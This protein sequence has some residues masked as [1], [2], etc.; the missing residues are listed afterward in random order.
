MY[1]AETSSAYVLSVYLLATLR[2]DLPYF[3]LPVGRDLVRHPLHRHRR[4]TRFRNFLQ[5]LP[6]MMSRM[7][8]CFLTSSLKLCVTVSCRFILFK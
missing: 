8:C 1:D 7:F 3:L 2:F 6:Q 5:D 4:G